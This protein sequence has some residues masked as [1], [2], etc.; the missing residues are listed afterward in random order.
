MNFYY[1]ID[2]PKLLSILGIVCVCVAEK[3]V[4]VSEMV[5]SELQY[6]KQ[7]N[8]SFDDVLREVLG[9]K[10]SLDDLV[11]YFDKE[12]QDTCIELI[13]HINEQG[14]FNHRIE[15]GS[16]ADVLKFIS[17]GTIVAEA[18]FTEHSMS[19][20]YRDRS[21]SLERFTGLKMDDNEV[22]STRGGYTHGKES[23][24]ERV[25]NKIPGSYRRWGK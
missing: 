4:K 19:L 5:H 20:Y 1:I 13:D 10:P 15:E 6:R 17:E 21:S 12:L 9:L 2:T 18:R 22:K 7:D 14:D 24:F 11:A 8:D 16:R 23:A 25:E 3:T